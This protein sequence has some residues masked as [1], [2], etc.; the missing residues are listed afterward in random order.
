LAHA[1]ELA[2]DCRYARLAGDDAVLANALTQRIQVLDAEER[3]A[4][5]RQVTPLLRR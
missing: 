3:L 1:R 4:A 5:L 2:D